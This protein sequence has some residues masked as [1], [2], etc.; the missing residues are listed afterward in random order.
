MTHSI[1]THSIMTHSIMT[2]SI[3]TLNI[4][5]LTIKRLFETIT[6]MTRSITVLGAKCYYDECH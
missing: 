4:M 6:I 2:H 5:T 3:M 1:I